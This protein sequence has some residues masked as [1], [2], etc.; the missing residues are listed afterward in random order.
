MPRPIIPGEKR[1]LNKCVV[2]K[3]ANKVYDL[4]LENAP[5]YRVWSYR[6]AAWAIEGLEQDIGLLYRTMGLMGL[7]SIPDVGEKL[8]SDIEDWIVNA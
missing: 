4:E 1:A 7:Q 2:E 5:D 3:L 6:K 8:G